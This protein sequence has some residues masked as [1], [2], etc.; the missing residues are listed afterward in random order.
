MKPSESNIID[1]ECNG[2]NVKEITTSDENGNEINNKILYM[3]KDLDLSKY[4][5][6][7]DVNAQNFNVMVHAF[8]SKVQQ[9]QLNALQADSQALLSGSYVVYSKGNYHTFRPQGYIME[10]DDDDIG[11]AYYKDFGSGYKKDVDELINN[12]IEGS[13]HTYRD[14]IPN[15]LKKK[16][17]L[18]NEQY[19]ELYESIKGKPLDVLEQEKPCVAMALKDIFKDMEIKK[20]KFNRDYNEILFRKGTPS[21]IFFVGKD[22]EGNRYKVEDIPA[23]FRKY[24]QDNDLPI[25]YFGE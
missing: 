3:S 1:V 25:I 22:K 2:V 12:Y 16:L 9:A 21:A 10:V 6:D 17:N 8:D 11:A 23:E 7:K 5:F 24:A 15:L 20:R 14:Y 13:A 4:G 19:I 18:T